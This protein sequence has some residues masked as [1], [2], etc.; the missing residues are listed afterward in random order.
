[1][2]LKHTLYVITGAN[3]GFGKAIT[4]TLS[5][6]A[7][8]PKTSIVLVGRDEKQLQEIKLSNDKVTCH[9]IAN[10]NLQGSQ[11]AKESVI[12]KLK[13]MLQ[14]RCYYTHIGILNCI[15]GVA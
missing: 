3:R 2:L 10:A 4:E 13:I 14:V 6:K 5:K 15:Q 12:E 8:D 1:M 7:K 9:Y 11:E